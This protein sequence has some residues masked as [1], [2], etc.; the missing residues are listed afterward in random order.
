MPE[1]KAKDES[2]IVNRNEKSEVE[3]VVIYNPIT[4]KPEM[5]KVSQFGVEDFRELLNKRFSQKSAQDS[6]ESLNIKPNYL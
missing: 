3:N 6:T 4:H 1:K 2:V 5:F